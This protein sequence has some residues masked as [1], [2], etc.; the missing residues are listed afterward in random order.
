M[1]R[2]ALIYG[3]TGQVVEMYPPEEVVVAEGA[4]TAAATY[5]VWEADQSN[6]DTPILTGNATLDSVATTVNVASGPSQTDRRKISLASLTGIETRRQYLAANA[7]KQR[8]VVTPFEVAAAHVTVENDLAFDFPI[9]TSTFKGLRQSFVIDA[10]FIADADNI[11][12]G[13]RLMP[14]YRV[15]WTWATPAGLSRHLWTYFDVVR[16]AGMR[17]VTAR[18][19]LARFPD[20][21]LMEWREQRGSGFERQLQAA[22]R[23]FV[24]DL[25]VNQL[26]VNQLRDGPVVDHCVE[27]AF[28]WE[29]GRAGLA[30]FGRATEAYVAA[31]RED[32]KQAFAEA[33]KA[34]DKPAAPID[35][36]TTGEV[37]GR[38]VARPFFT[39]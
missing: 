28:L 4:P 7:S 6:D 27:L 15:Q 5:K 32:Y 25:T 16:Q 30:P 11:N 37:S 18:S 13:E 24:F 22:W 34:P 26:D 14:P 23:T 10:T 12:T 39:R 38:N 29:L 8:Q 9:T 36:G 19:A 1:T 3:L 20:A 17:M 35:T 2:Q 31:A 33:F 21:I